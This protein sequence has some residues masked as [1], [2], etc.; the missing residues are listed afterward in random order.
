[1]DDGIKGVILQSLENT[2]QLSANQHFW[3]VVVV[4]V[5]VQ[6]TLALV[7]YFGFTKNPNVKANT[8]FQWFVNKIRAIMLNSK[9]G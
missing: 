7:N 2:C 8:I 5:I 9:R 6:F 3:V 1:M 4:Q